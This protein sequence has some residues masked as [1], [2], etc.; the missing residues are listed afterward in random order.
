MCSPH[1]S[2]ASLLS[3][4]LNQIYC[5]S[6][7]DTLTKAAGRPLPAYLSNRCTC[8]FLLRKNS[9]LE[10]SGRNKSF[11]FTPLL[12]FWGEF[13][14][15]GPKQRGYEWVVSL[16]WR[17]VVK[18]VINCVRS[19]HLHWVIYGSLIEQKRR[20]GGTVGGLGGRAKLCFCLCLGKT[21]RAERNEWEREHS[22]LFFRSSPCLLKNDRTFIRRGERNGQSYIVCPHPAHPK[23][24]FCPS[25]TGILYYHG[26]SSDLSQPL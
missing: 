23:S 2:P 10:R 19:W 20:V 3:L 22:S 25:A 15:L 18:A 26:C 7:F 17:V 8:E 1:G 5:H 24:C 11:S 16:S 12:F 21:L 6:I 14:S 9:R 4:S 13:L